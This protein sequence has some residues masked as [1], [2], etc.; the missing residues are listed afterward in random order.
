[1]SSRQ[2]DL[3]IYIERPPAEVYS[4]WASAKSLASWFAPM[5]EQV[6]DVAMEF[7]IG[8]NYSIVM[9]LP[10]GSVHTT[11][12]I[13]R[14]IVPNERIVMT[15]HCDAFTDP[16]SIVDVSFTPKGNGTE[17]HLIHQTF[18]SAETCE[19][20]SGGWQACLGQLARWLANK[21]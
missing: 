6:P 12:G 16:D 7:I 2:I 13:F 17:V 11:K 5:A 19:A 1:M 15:W 10:D 21:D 9:P 18:A 20:H 3:T 4:A 14:V 8:G